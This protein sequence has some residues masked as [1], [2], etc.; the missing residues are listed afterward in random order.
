MA[1]E[2]LA[3]RW[4]RAMRRLADSPFALGLAGFA[5]TTALI[6]TGSVSPF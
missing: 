3:R 4:S 6:Q 1:R 5:L 2:A